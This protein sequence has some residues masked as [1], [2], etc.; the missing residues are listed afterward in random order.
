MAA[1]SKPLKRRKLLVFL[2]ALAILGGSAMGAG[3]TYIFDFPELEYLTN[4]QPSTVTRVFSRNGKV[5]AEFYRERRIP[6][7][8]AKIPVRLRQAFLAIEDNRFYEHPGVSYP[9]ILRAFVRNL[10]AGKKVQGGST[11][12]QQLAKVIFLT[13]ERTYRRK[14]REAIL[15][16]EIERRFTKDEILEFYF[17][18]IYLGSGAYGVEAAARI[19]FGKSTAQLT[20]AEMALIGGMPKAPARSNPRLHPEAARQRRNLVLRRMREAGYITPSQEAAAVEESIRLVPPLN[21]IVPEAAYFTEMLRKRLEKRYGQALYQGGLQVHTT[22]D[23]KL[24]KTAHKNFLKGIESANALRGFLPAG[25]R[26]NRPP[27]LGDGFQFYVSEIKD[28]IIRGNIGGYEAEMTIPPDASTLNLREGDLVLGRAVKVDRLRKTMSLVWE[29]SIQGAVVALDPATG[30]IQAMVGGTN[31]RRFQFNRAVQAQRQPG[32]AFKPIIMA[33]ALTMG[34]T[35]SHILMDSPFVRRLPGTEKAW[36]PRNYSNKFYGPV[37]LRDALVKSLNLAT[38]KLLEQVTPVRAVEF[39]RKLGI[40]SEMKP[41]LSL[42]LGTFEVSP[43]EFTGAYIPFATDGVN[44]R[45]YAIVKITDASNHILEENVPQTHRVISPE[46]AYQ[47]KMLLRGV[48]T[49]GTGISAR[50]LPAFIAGKTGTTNNYRDAWFV[51]F[52]DNL[53]VGTWV[54]RDDNKDMG[55]RASGASAALPIWKEIMAEWLK[56]RKNGLSA[57]EPPPGIKLVRVDARTG[58]LPSAKCGGKQLTEAFVQGTEP[59]EGCTPRQPLRVF[60]GSR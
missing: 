13:P 57:P 22:L 47:I 11:I 53:I 48:I 4:Y 33:A 40:Q 36:K 60:S 6:I 43:L 39:A 25:S 20:L 37:T 2:I 59:T 34:Y 24:Q 29:I 7:S 17:N 38:I 51:G 3:Y 32:S 15:A 41:Y 5:I 50:R 55:F 8:L 12:T 45:P 10:R 30:A 42:G 27:R 16:L 35:P 44:A 23:L 26:R 18:Q 49:N 1:P 46:T 52:S 28:K 14:I 31:F 54:G 19:Y 56:E 58:L 21:S 9:D